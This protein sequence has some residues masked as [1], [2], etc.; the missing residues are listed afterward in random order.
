MN[1]AIYALKKSSK[2]LNCNKKKFIVV[3][4]TLILYTDIKFG[5]LQHKVGL[6]SKKW[7][8]EK[9]II[10][11]TENIHFI[12]SQKRRLL[13]LPEL[14]TYMTLS[15]VNAGLVGL[16]HIQKLCGCVHHLQGVLGGTPTSCWYILR[17][18][19]SNGSTT[20][21]LLLR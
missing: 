21:P 20:W 7:R 17:Q 10:Y 3:L 16:F 6:I 18:H 1:L 9:F 5:A 19:T 13:Q 12:T 2:E 15:Y 14:I 8:L 4:S 11:N